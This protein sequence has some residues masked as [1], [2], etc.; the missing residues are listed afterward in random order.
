MRP[1]TA[2]TFLPEL[3]STVWPTELIAASKR[4]DLGAF[5]KIHYVPLINFNSRQIDMRRMVPLR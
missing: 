4:S 2:E 3:F 1:A 5:C